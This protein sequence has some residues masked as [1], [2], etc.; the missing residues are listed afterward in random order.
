M[1]ALWL[2]LW[3]LLAQSPVD[4]SIG[5][6]GDIDAFMEK[7]LERRDVNWDNFYNY[8]TN[9]RAEL[10]I[11]GSIDS[12]PLHGFRREFLWFVK[13]GYLVRSPRSV[14]GVSLSPEES[15]KAEDA[16]IE[17][18]KKREEKRQR[19]L[20]LGEGPKRDAFFG[21]EFEPGNYLVVGSETFKGRDVV[22]VEYYP[23][24]LF[25]D[26]D[27]EEGAEDS[28]EED[29]IEEALNKVFLVTMLIDP[30]EHQIVRMTLDNYGFDFLPAKWL[31]QLDT[32]EATI[33]MTKAFDEIWLPLSIEAFGK[34]VTAVGDLSVRFDS[35]FYDYAKAETGATYRFPPRGRGP[36]A[37]E[38]PKKNRQR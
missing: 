3:V 16:W 36:D 14:D 25:N 18:E 19:E 7:V 22:V 34:V 38:K 23:E 1:K 32:V 11:E 6:I 21:F 24:K 29:A 20:D 12:V 10:S 5:D 31:V 2:S 13:E 30:A 35:T 26:D 4:S 9:E 8:F 33:E 15:E 17:R 27:D 28:E 37:P